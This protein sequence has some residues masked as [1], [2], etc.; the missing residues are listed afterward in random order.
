MMRPNSISVC[1]LSGFTMA[2]TLSCQ[3]QSNEVAV[4][5]GIDLYVDDIAD[6]SYEALNVGE[7]YSMLGHLFYEGGYWYLGTASEPIFQ[8]SGFPANFVECLE[9]G[10]NDQVVVSGRLVSR[11]EISEVHYVGSRNYH[12]YEGA[13][14][15][16]TGEYL[17]YP[18]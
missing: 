10:L 11:T 12:G 17:R 15:G 2:M 9:D 6:Q 7:R 14:G 4:F 18:G 16:G 3:D 8:L 13:C 5:R 1:I